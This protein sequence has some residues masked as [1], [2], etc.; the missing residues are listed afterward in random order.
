MKYCNQLKKLVILALFGICILDTKTAVNSTGEAIRLCLESLIPS[1]FPLMVL[2]N[3]ARSQLG[4]SKSLRYAGALFRLPKGYEGVLLSAFFA[5][6][7]IGAAAVG[8]DFRK[9]ILT[10]DEAERLL[11][12]CSNA[13]PAFIFGF[14]SHYFPSLQTLFVIWLL[15]VYSAWVICQFGSRK[16]KNIPAEN[17]QDS[18]ISQAVQSASKAMVSLCSWVIVFKVLLAYLCKYLLI[19]MPPHFLVPIVGIT[20][21]SNGCLLLSYIEDPEMRFL[22][23]NAMVAFGGL[24]VAMQTK[25][26]IDSLSLKKYLC[27]KAAQSAITLPLS[28]MYL[29]MD[30]ISFSLFLLT[31]SVFLLLRKKVVDFLSKFIYNQFYKNRRKQHVVS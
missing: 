15:Q 19:G 10:R 3:I 4:G 6:Y 26:L 14:L 1:L 13:G 20:E 30:L 24:C 21:L 2:S 11:S 16:Q 9:G 8:S 27:A 23:C 18:S 29:R 12:F 5:G 31:L 25:E 7:P 17:Q 22:I 28:V